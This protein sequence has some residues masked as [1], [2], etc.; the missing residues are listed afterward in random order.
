MQQLM[1]G[2]LVP[3]KT[4]DGTPLFRDIEVKALD[5][6]TVGQPEVTGDISGIVYRLAFLGMLNLFK[7]VTT[8]NTA[9]PEKR[10]Q[11]FLA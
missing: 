1:Q 8:E 10:W 4:A 9:Y 3:M 5:E 2:K 7:E 6:L 11:A